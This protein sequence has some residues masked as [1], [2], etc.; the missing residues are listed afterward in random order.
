MNADVPLPYW[1]G[2][3]VLVVVLLTVDLVLHRGKHGSS[4]KAAVAWSIAWVGA[5]L[6]FNG[7][8]W[9]FLGAEAGQQFLSAYLLEKSLS[10]DNLFVFLIVFA[11]LKIPADEQH[12]VLSWGVFGA[13]VTRG[14][15][16]ALGAAL[17]SRWHVLVYI[18]GGLLIVSGLRMLRKHDE[19][20]DGEGKLLGWLQRH[21]P[22]TKERHGHAFVVKEGTRRVFTPLFLALITIELTDVVFAVDSVPAAF[23]VSDHPFIIYSSNVFAILGLRALFVVLARALKGLRYLNYGLAA[24]L[25]FAGA[26]MILGHW[27]HLPPLVS[28]AIITACIGTAVIA[29]LVARRSERRGMRKASPSHA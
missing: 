16:I 25:V 10:V 21:L 9:W 4:P 1:I 7:F 17:L 28:L 19:E 14:I 26:K 15:F 12:R 18:F 11:R 24:V 6:A 2:F 20:K 13:I 5:G 22:I 3:V 23:A 8:V 29:S 27:T